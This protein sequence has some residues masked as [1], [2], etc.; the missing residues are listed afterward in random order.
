MIKA[1]LERRP[2]SKL[3]LL[4]IML[5]S[6]SSFAWAYHVAKN[7]SFPSSYGPWIQRGR[8]S[9]D[10]DLKVARG[11]DSHDE[12]CDISGRRIM[13]RSALAGTGLIVATALSS[14]LAHADDVVPE[15]ATPSKTESGLKYIDLEEGN[16][17]G[18]T[19]RYGQL[20]VVSYTGYMKLPNSSTKKKFASASG[21][22][23]KHGNGKM[24]AGLDEGLHT[25]KMGG[26]RRLVIPPKLGFVTSGLGPMPEL[27]WQRWKLNSLLED[28]ITQRGGNL[29][30]DVRLESFFDDEADQG[31][32]EDDEISPEERAEL[33]SRIQRSQRGERPI[34][35]GGDPPIA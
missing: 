23:V 11:S 20:C 34:L 8:K 32:Y 33:E 14:T 24:I 12:R 22:I 1:I 25:M 21:F 28:M 9:R 30:Y 26:L 31:Y 5:S 3:L 16:S 6:T 18:P 13:L 35:E 17:G 29:I 4:G 10:T 19:P 27:P 2:S 7:P 15:G